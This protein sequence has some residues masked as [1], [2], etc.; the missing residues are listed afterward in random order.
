MQNSFAY[1]KKVY[2]EAKRCWTVKFGGEKDAFLQISL[3][4]NVI[5]LKEEVF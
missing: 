3:P 4:G 1:K 5:A 2:I